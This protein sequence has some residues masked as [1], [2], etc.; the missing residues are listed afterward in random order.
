MNKK[1]LEAMSDLQINTLIAKLEQMDVYLDD[2]GDFL[3]EKSAGQHGDDIIY[4]PCNDPSD[5]MPLAFEHNITVGNYDGDNF[6]FSDFESG[7]HEELWGNMVYH[8]NSL[9]A[10]AIVYLL[11]KES[12]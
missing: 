3:W 7:E 8:K 12:K 6:A 5:M 1:Q 10:A 9:R 2:G 4:D 11:I